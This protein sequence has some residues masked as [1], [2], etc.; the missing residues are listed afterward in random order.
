MKQPVLCIGEVLWDALPGGLFLGGAP[1][2]A[3]CHLHELGEPVLFASRVGD[4][5]LGAEILRRMRHRGMETRLVQVD[6]SLP[7]GF[8]RVGLDASGSPDFTILEPSAWDEVVAT[9]DL[10]DAARSAS[11]VVYGSLAQRGTKTR[12]TIAWITALADERVFDVNLRPP[13]DHRDIVEQSIA[14]ASFVKLN[15]DEL[16][17]LASWFGLP[18]GEEPSARAL[19]GRFGIDTLCVTRGSNGAALLDAGVWH[20]HPGFRVDV[21]DTV[22]SGDAF[23]AGMLAQRHAGVE[24][25]EA[26]D[27]ANALGAYVA[28]QHGATPMHDAEAIASLRAVGA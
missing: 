20:E 7:T 2:N 21:A 10:L 27:Y 24:A 5:L 1:F 22:G 3:A 4:D 9:D 12:A 23:M 13:Y 15:D 19:A 6:D 26:L 18:D 8:V 14:D 11:A 28:G 25:S 17:T 16:R